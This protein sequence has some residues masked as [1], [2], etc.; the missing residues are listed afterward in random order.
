MAT[1]STG[2]FSYT[3]HAISV[4]DNIIKTQ[5]LIDLRKSEF[6]W[7]ESV[8]EQF[9]RFI[10]F[11]SA[12]FFMYKINAWDFSLYSLLKIMRRITEKNSFLK[13]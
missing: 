9:G 12:N 13:H 1:Q 11:N 6:F 4:A 7:V 2:Q 8:Y 3:R 5:Q 10:H